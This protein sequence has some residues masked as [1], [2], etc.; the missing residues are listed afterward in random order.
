MPTARSSNLRRIAQIAALVLSALVV[1]LLLAVGAFAIWLRNADLAPIVA[2]KAGE[3]LGRKVTLGGLEIDWGDPIGVDITD[4]RIAS[5]PW[6]SQSDLTR[7]DLIRIGHFAALLDVG[8][9]WRGVLRYERLRVVD[10]AVVLERDPHGIGNWKFGPG[11]GGGGFALVPKNRTQFPTLIDFVGEDARITYRTR[12][13]SILR[14]DLAKVAI[15]S[16]DNDTPVTLQAEGAYNGVATRIAATTESFAKLRDASVPFGMPFTMTAKETTIAFDGTAM[17]PLDFQGVRGALTL[18][19][20]TL[21]DILAA[22]DAKTR[23]DLPLSIAGALA[24]DGDRWSLAAAKGKLAK[25]DFAGDL[26]LLEG[27]AGAPDDVALDLDFAPLDLDPLLAATGGGTDKKEQGWEATPLQAQALKDLMLSADLTT[28]LLSFG[29]TRLPDFALQ[30]RA[31][32]GKITLKQLRFAFGGGTLAF[33]GELDGAG[34][35]AALALNARLKGAAVGE[36]SKMLGGAGDEIRGRLDGAATLSLRG[37]TLGEGLRH[38]KGAALLT[39][40][41]GDVARSLIEQVSADLR[42]IFREKA[43]RVKV[44]CLLAALS[45]KDGI[46]QLAPLRLESDAA[47]L[48]GAGTV[49]LIKKSLDLTIQTERDSTNFFALDLPIRVSG[50]FAKL[51]AEPQLGADSGLPADDRARTIG[52]LPASLREMAQGNA[53]LQ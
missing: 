27:K 10:V 39:L 40:A 23:I 53:C 35:S 32:G 51:A 11:A 7:P 45:L 37:A 12:S 34:K 22:M 42:S 47:I 30:G 16:P 31:A 17:E 44:T 20:K 9:L 33:S 38:S 18:D 15:A 14:I 24:H 5:A 4:L 19:A 52:R 41:K 28:P 48:H 49:D 29:K 43:G 13:G 1:V 50:P 21:N 25:T 3:A 8:D 46:G 36:I 2:E 6:G 26:A